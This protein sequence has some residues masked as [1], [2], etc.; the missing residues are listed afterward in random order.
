MP[1]AK[2]TDSDTDQYQRFLEAAREL[3]CDPADPRISEV[4]RGM[5]ALPHRPRQK[6]GEKG[7]SRSAAAKA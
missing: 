5:A 1:K 6:G 2:L 3:G 7:R 4:L